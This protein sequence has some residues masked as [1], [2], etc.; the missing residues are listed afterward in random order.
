MNKCNNF[1]S[2]NSPLNE[3]LISNF[4]YHF[5]LKCLSSSNCHLMSESLFLFLFYFFLFFAFRIA[6]TH[7][8]AHLNVSRYRLSKWQ[9]KISAAIRCYRWFGRER[10]LIHCFVYCVN[11]FYCVY[12]FHISYKQF[13][14]CLNKATNYVTGATV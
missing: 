1:Y 6:K 12:H 13:S 3:M 2:L 7:P 10:T 11:I 8:E 5:S 9:C 4:F 14:F